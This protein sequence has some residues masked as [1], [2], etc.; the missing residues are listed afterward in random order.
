MNHSISQVL[1]MFK[2]VL[3]DSKPSGDSLGRKINR[4]CFSSVST[5]RTLRTH[6]LLAAGVAKESQAPCPIME[7]GAWQ[8]TFLLNLQLPIVNVLNWKWCKFYDLRAH[9][10]DQVLIPQEYPRG[11]LDKKLAEFIE[12]RGTFCWI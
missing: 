5:V 12:N 10:I 7:R 1:F 3:I 6:A 9:S 2:S 11:L 4:Y 8:T